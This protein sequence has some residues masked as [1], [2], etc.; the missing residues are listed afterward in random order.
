MVHAGVELGGGGQ[1]ARFVTGFL[2]A[3][4]DR[5]APRAVLITLIIAFIAAVNVSG[6][7]QSSLVVNLLTLG[8]LLP[9]AVF[10][11]AGL[12]FVDWTRLTGPARM[13]VADLSSS[14]LL[15]VYAF[16]GYE[17]IPV[18]AGETRNPR[19]DVPFALIMT[20]LVVT[21][22]HDTGAGRQHRHAP[23]AR[24]IDDATG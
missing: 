22:R 16:G 21:C 19:R 17:V 24:G 12:W 10:I 20:I 9:L 14:A 15:L 7:R 1:R 2:L 18:V 11:V 4:S 3:G 23:G 13:S 6:I 5:H 8:K